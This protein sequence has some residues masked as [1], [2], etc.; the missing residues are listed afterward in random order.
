MPWGLAMIRA[1]GVAIIALALALAVQTW[2]LSSAQEA[3]DRAELRAQGF[4]EA[5]RIHARHVQRAEAERIEAAALD[6][7]LQEGVGAD[8]P[9][10]DY[11]RRGAGRVWP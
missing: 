1:A 2:R 3:R 11:L 6:R 9:L 8:A 7:E 4:E 10:S 5:A